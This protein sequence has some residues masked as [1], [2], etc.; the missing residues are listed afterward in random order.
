MQ[1]NLLF[2]VVLLL[3]N[4]IIS[5]SQT[6]PVFISGTCTDSTVDKVSVVSSSKYW[7]NNEPPIILAE[8][9]KLPNNEFQIELTIL[10]PEKVRLAIHGKGWDIFITPGDSIIFNIIILLYSH[11]VVL[12]AIGTIMAVQ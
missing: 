8:A 2:F 3:S 9:D 6:K 1:R 12:C 5:F 11:N 4:S 10:H 7:W